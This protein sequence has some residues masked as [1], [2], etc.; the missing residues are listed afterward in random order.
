MEDGAKGAEKTAASG[1]QISLLAALADAC[2]LEYVVSQLTSAAALATLAR[3]SV[4]LRA[5]VIEAAEAW[6]ALACAEGVR[7]RASSRRLVA[8]ERALRARSAMILSRRWRL[9]P[10]ESRAT[11]RGHHEWVISLTRAGSLAV[12]GSDDGSIR[13]WDAIS[14]GRAAVLPDAHRMPVTCVAALSSTIGPEDDDDD[15]TAGGRIDSASM[16]GGDERGSPIAWLASGSGELKVAL[17]R[18]RWPTNPNPASN[19]TP[20]ASPPQPIPTLPTL[21]TI[22]PI[23]P[24]TSSLAEGAA[25]LAANAFD[26]AAAAAA[27][28]ASS[29]APPAAAHGPTAAAGGGLVTLELTGELAG[30]TDT[31][32]ALTKLPNGLVASAS[33]DH[34]VRIWDA[35]P[36][37]TAPAAAPAPAPDA[38]ASAPASAP[39]SPPA[40]LVPPSGGS[41]GAAAAGEL[42]PPSAPSAPA[43][44]VLRGHSSGVVSLE[45]CIT[46]LNEPRWLHTQFSHHGRDGGQ[47]GG[48]DG[49]KDGGQDTGQSAAFKGTRPPPPG[50]ATGTGECVLASGGYDGTVRLWDLS[51]LVHAAG[52]RASR[53]RA[54]SADHTLAAATYNEPLVTAGPSSCGL[55]RGH[56]AWVTDIVHLG[57]RLASASYDCSVRVWTDDSAASPPDALR[58]RRPTP[59]D[60]SAPSTSSSAPMVLL[61]DFQVTSLCA[62]GSSSLLAAGGYDHM[63]HI[64]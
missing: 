12:S 18:L 56:S 31:I 3:C 44:C 26:L 59:A 27:V 7:V 35:R 62:V 10:I 38:H 64:W 57:T 42:L 14:G 63:V 33:N 32:W 55:L 60:T 20:P 47:D 49:G 15:E 61:H 4:S 13:C 5:T 21:N 24:L 16:G 28:G 2:I 9:G 17:W 40:V 54:A 30:H 11:L 58:R 46:S 1:E 53:Q 50:G 23:S 19:S 39:P 29:P 45:S 6:E 51:A 34:T 8:V 41:G 43:L 25:A 22:P 36:L 48:Q 37:L 52:E